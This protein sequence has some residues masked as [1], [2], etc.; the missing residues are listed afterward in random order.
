VLPAFGLTEI[1]EFVVTIPLVW[2]NAELFLAVTKLLFK[3]IFPDTV[4]FASV[5][6]RVVVLAALPPPPEP[7]ETEAQ[8]NVPVPVIVD[9][10]LNPV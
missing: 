2:V 10:E 5:E 7:T 4:R 1:I 9:R 8:T 3:I 6:V